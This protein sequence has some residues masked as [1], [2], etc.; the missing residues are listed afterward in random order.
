MPTPSSIEI[1]GTILD[2]FDKHYRLFRE[3]SAEAKRRWE[4]GAW[5]DVR[6]ASRMRIGMYDQRVREAVAEIRQR[7]EGGHEERLWPEIKRTF[8]G[9]L[10]EHRQPECAE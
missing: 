6:E 8:I 3:T 5:T 2:G 9:L 1:A 10:L 4:R 7:F